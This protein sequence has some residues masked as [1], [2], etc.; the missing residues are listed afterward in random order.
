MAPQQRNRIDV[1][2]A[3][4]LKI[5]SAEREVRKAIEDLR[6][7]EKS[8]YVEALEKS[9]DLVA[10]ESRVDRFLR[11]E[12]SNVNAAARLQARYWKDRKAF[13]GE[14]AFLPLDDLSG[15][16]ALTTDDIDALALGFMVRI[17]D[18][19]T[20]R[21]SLLID[22]SRGANSQVSGL[23]R[24]HCL[25]Y[26]LSIQIAQN[27]KAQTEG[28]NMIRI[29]NDGNSLDRSVLMKMINVIHT[30]I[31]VKIFS[32][33]I[34][35]LPS[36]EERQ[37]QLETMMPVLAEFTS[38]IKATRNK[39]HT[40]E[41]RQEILRKLHTDGIPQSA[42][43]SAL[44]GSWCYETFDS[45]FELQRKG[46]SLEL[47]C[48]TSAVIESDEKIPAIDDSFV[49]ASRVARAEERKERK[50]QLDVIYARKRREREKE[51]TDSLQEQCYRLNQAN[52]AL[53]E[54]GDNLE[55][56]LGEARR[57]VEVLEATQL[58][59]AQH[60]APNGLPNAFHNAGTTQQGS[61][62]GNSNSNIINQSSFQ[63]Q[64][65]QQLLG[66]ATAAAPPPNQA[67]SSIQGLQCQGSPT[68]EV[69]LQ[70]LT[71]TSRNANPQDN[72]NNVITAL[73][74]VTPVLS[75][76]QTNRQS[77]DVL[78]NILCQVVALLEQQNRPQQVASSNITSKL[79][80]LLPLV[81]Q[82][83]AQQFQTQQQPTPQPQPVQ[84]D[85]NNM[86]E[87][88]LRLLRGLR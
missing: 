83:Q 22:I 56:L 71:L 84:A 32:S 80:Q 2:D 42:L 23:T 81:Q 76:L 38:A 68:S 53:K 14:R 67:G 65:L 41:D 58:P 70:L 66:A 19:S 20:G 10:A 79:I 47:G 29:V 24:L 73:Q 1:K 37:Q 48:A 33:H 50:R 26:W 57:M 59:A 16:G 9:P 44:G 18:D 40:T 13:F 28:F 87:Q 60:S 63:Q 88:L 31:P 82:L 43:P 62:D 11:C 52:V 74:Q 78:T 7:S 54:Q 77:Q 72:P 35:V 46:T 21:P 34:C 61:G 86:Q 39:I 49:E 4:S 69:L 8:A 25:F 64:L 75:L 85:P 6:D 45:W 15:A 27:P 30:S 36:A 51:D 3:A 5:S 55:R 12:K 17:P